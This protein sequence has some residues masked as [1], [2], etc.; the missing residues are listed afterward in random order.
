MAPDAVGDSVSA[1][2]GTSDQ[3]EPLSSFGRGPLGPR[4]WLSSLLASSVIYVAIAALLVMFSAGTVIIKKAPV[5]LTFIEKVVKAPEPPPPVAVTPPEPVA[6]P[7]AAAAMA[8]V[9]RPDQKIRKLDKPP[10]PKELVAPKEVPKQAPAEADAREDKGVAVYGEPG[11][12]D[13][14]GLEGGVAKGGRL[15]GIAGGVVDLPPG[16]NPPVKTSGDVPQYPRQAKA[17]E[18]EGVVVLKIIV[19]ADGSVSKV[20]VVEGEEPFVSAAVRAVKEW[21]YRAAQ[22]DGQAIAVYHTVRIPF[23]L[24]NEG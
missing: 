5:S 14:A 19:L 17:A 10:P 15:G 9:V 1:A 2:R 20:E 24:Q 18:L 12:G 21:H 6:K 7:Q 4:R 13:P 22:H 16:A 23:K 11:T 8:P 3:F